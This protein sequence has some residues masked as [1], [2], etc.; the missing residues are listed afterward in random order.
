MSGNTLAHTDA[1]TDRHGA[2][3][4]RDH[5]AAG[6][7]ARELTLKRSEFDIAVHLGRIRT[8]SAEGGRGT[9]RVPL[10]EIER[11][12]SRPDFP[13]GLRASVRTVGSTEGAGLMAVPKARFTRLARLGLLVPV[14]FYLN[15]YRAVVW[16]YLADELRQ[17]AADE[18]SAPLL[19]GRLPEDLRERLATGADLRP[20]NWRGRH[21]GFLL[22]KADDPWARAAA[23]AALLEEAEVA[24]TVRDP[25]ERAYLH[26]LRPALPVHGSPGSPAALVAEEIM[27]ASEPDEIDWLRADL[28]GAVDTARE[29]LPAPRPAPKAAP[30]RSEPTAPEPVRG[31]G[32]LGRLFRGGG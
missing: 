1:T 2:I 29:H 19:K 12:R 6:H 14:R 23:V 25:Y 32:L 7:A 22:R 3:I 13:E 31:R 10:A 11:L 16:L 20:R 28:A 17:F 21:L 9:P 4:L 5:L 27:T 24:E 30:E 26:R 8:V 15:R 18:K